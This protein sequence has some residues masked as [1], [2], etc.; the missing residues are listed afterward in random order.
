MLLS[1]KG[2]DIRAILNTN[3]V[4]FFVGGRGVFIIIILHRS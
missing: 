3:A 1:Y 2:R 4:V